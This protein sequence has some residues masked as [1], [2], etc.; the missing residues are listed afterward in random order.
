SRP[1]GLSR[2][3]QVRL[4]VIDLS[5]RNSRIVSDSGQGQAGKSLKAA[6]NVTV[7]LA[8][9]SAANMQAEATPNPG[10]PLAKATFDCTPSSLIQLRPKFRQQ[11]DKTI[12]ELNRRPLR[13]RHPLSQSSFYLRP[14]LS[15]NDLP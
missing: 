7:E 4:K 6:F 1:P 3:S 13:R 2:P 12:E 14:R 10:K 8:V 5:A 11:E 9:K 15:R